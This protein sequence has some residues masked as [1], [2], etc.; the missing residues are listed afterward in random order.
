MAKKC[1]LLVVLAVIVAGGVFAQEEGGEPWG[2][3][4]NFASGDLGLLVFGARYERLFTP[5][6]SAGAVFYWANSFILF[7]ELEFGIFGRYYIWQGL[8]AELGLG[9]HTHSA[10]EEYEYTNYLGQKSTAS[11]LVVNVGFGI[12]PGLGWKFD[13]GKPGGFFVEPGIIIPITIGSKQY[14]FQDDESG[15]SVGFVVY[16]GLGW[17]F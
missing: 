7:N 8:Y 9:Y 6:I 4:K 12:S 2:G 13:P 1:L 11:D 14:V 5:Q 10:I 16:C 15:V 3:K 17:A